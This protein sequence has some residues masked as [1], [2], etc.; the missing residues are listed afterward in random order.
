M[1]DTES[2]LGH[3]LLV[4]F[5]EGHLGLEVLLEGRVHLD[6]GV[7][8]LPIIQCVVLHRVNPL[9]R[10]VFPV[11]LHQERREL[12]AVVNRALLLFTLILPPLD[13][14]V[15]TEPLL[16]FSIQLLNIL[17]KDLLLKRNKLCKI[18]NVRSDIEIQVFIHDLLLFTHL[19]QFRNILR[20][21]LL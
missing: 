5:V 16:L 21:R 6:R 19:C 20:Y 1:G 7:Q 17:H 15:N 8:I 2:V 3:H 13:E 14:L 10:R 12:F 9:L 11:V 18:I 4:L